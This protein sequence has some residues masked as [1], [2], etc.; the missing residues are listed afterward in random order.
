MWPSSRSPLPRVRRIG[1]IVLC[2]AL[3]LLTG[4]PVAAHESRQVGTYTL[5]VGLL[6][7]PVY[8]GQR[9]G[10]D[11]IVTRAGNPVVGLDR[12]LRADV[13]YETFTMALTIEPK[14]AGEAGY[15]ATFIPTAAGEYTFH[16][17]GT[18]EGTPVDQSFSS[19]PTTFDEV[20]ETASGE[21]PGALPTLAELAA[22]SKRGADAAGL[23]PIALGVGGA[24]VVVALLGLGIAFAAL[25]RGRAE[26]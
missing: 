19:G 22:Q 24:G 6:D 21:F 11:L 17:T 5:E 8:V 26:S 12:T 3:L 1:P 7:E 23:V 14:G 13:S 4:T 18:I 10:L 20:R 2:V 16:L 15:A 25:R 9:S